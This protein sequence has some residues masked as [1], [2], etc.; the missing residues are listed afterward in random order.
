MVAATDSITTHNNYLMS[1]RYCEC[2]R[3][4]T[5]AVNRAKSPR[6]SSKARRSDQYHDQCRQCFEREK[7]RLLVRW[8]RPRGE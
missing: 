8:L 3:R 4:I 7:T 2:K 1:P 5:V 6:A